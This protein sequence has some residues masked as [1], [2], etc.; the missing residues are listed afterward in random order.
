MSILMKAVSAMEKCFMDESIDSKATIT[1]GS[2][3]RGEEFCYEIAYTSDDPGH[4]PK[5]ALTLVIDS[6]V[7]DYLTVSMV[8]QVPVRVPCYNWADDNYLRK[9][10]GLFPDLLVPMTPD[11]PVFVT[12][13]ELKSLFLKVKVP[14]TLAGGDY[15]ITV[16]FMAGADVAAEST[17]NLHVIDAVLPKTNFIVTKWFHCDCIASYYDLE[18]FSEKHWDYIAKFMKTATENGINAILMPVFTPPLDTAVGG[19]R[20]TTQLVDVKKTADGW[21]FGMDKVERWV[22]TAKECGVEYYEVSHLYTQW[23]AGHAPKVMGYDENG[24]YRR[25]FGWETDSLSDEY[26]TFLRAFLTAFL[27]KMKELGV[28]K[29]C[30]FHISDEPSLDH[31]EPYRAAREQIA[32]LLDGYVVMDALSNFEFY[33]TGAIANPIPSNN[34]IDPFI[35]ANVPNLWTYYCCGQ[36][37]EVSNRFLA[38]PMQRTRVIGTQFWKYK[39]AGFL[40]WGYNFYYSQ[41]STRLIDPYQITDGDYFVPAGDC[42]AVYPGPKGQ[43]YETL[44]MKGFTMALSDMRAMYL[45]EEKCGREAVMKAL[46]EDLGEEYARGITF[47]QYPKEAAWLEGVRAKVNALIEA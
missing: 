43:P 9:E 21:E 32:D 3:L 17:I 14:E 5:C 23:G 18:T 26:R 46:E 41:G 42:F 1:A 35:E 8:E 27:A 33:K 13:R 37:N 4:H 12:Y 16:K 40:Q 10:P 22:K 44:H 47:S 30:L 15:P 24:E 2:A 25:L 39:I 6:P 7:K 34:H 29:Q 38:M 36:G 19:E 20:P 45:A 31:L 28:D 11:M